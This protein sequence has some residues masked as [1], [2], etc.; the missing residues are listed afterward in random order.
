MRDEV[1]PMASASSSVL[2]PCWKTRTA[3]AGSGGNVTRLN[4]RLTHA[5]TATVA[6]NAAARAHRIQ[7]HPVRG[8]DAPHAVRDRIDP[9]SLAELRGPTVV[10]TSVGRYA[11]SV[12]VVETARLWR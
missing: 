5:T 9:A 12:G 4:E 6:T 7:C 2:L 1:R 3:T 11:G 10:R 8:I